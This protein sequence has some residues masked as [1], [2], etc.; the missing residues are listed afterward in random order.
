MSGPLVLIQTS[1]GME[2]TSSLPKASLLILS[3]K[4]LKLENPNGETSMGLKKLKPSPLNGEEAVQLLSE[5]MNLESLDFED[6]EF[7]TLT[8]T[9][10]N[11]SSLLQN[12][13][14][15]HEK[16][17]EILSTKLKSLIQQQA[18]MTDL[19]E[20]Q[21][22]LNES[23]LLVQALEVTCKRMNEASIRDPLTGVLNRRCLDKEL[24]RLFNQAQ[25]EQS[26]L[27]CLMLDLD[28][29]GQINKQFG[30][31]VGD[32]I[33]KV[34]SQA[35]RNSI[36]YNDLLFRYGGDEFVIL[37]PHAS[38]DEAKEV[39]KRILINIPKV[40]KNILK[41]HR[42]LDSLSEVA[43]QRDLSASIGLFHQPLPEPLIT[44]PEE[45]IKFADFAANRA[46]NS[47]RNQMCTA[48]LQPDNY[49][50]IRTELKGPLI[51]HSVGAKS[52]F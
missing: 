1:T 16:D 39:A 21:A 46:K 34:T 42:P 38:Y 7:E 50:A 4:Y 17:F 2:S 25:A 41:G 47:G 52:S 3:S 24:N 33:L 9:S 15:D 43:I 30:H 45:F 51:R 49:I 32:K 37:L 19:H 11:V 10:T 44:H 5:P 28:H 14:P 20:L 27:S 23:H 48:T 13:E 29:F 31:E 26:D 18:A 8:S 40:T 36:R 6:L 35:I 22:S 12:P